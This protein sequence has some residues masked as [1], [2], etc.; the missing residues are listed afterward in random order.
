MINNVF[1]FLTQLAKR[2]IAFRGTLA[3]LAELMGFDEEEVINI[4]DDD[5]V[6]YLSSGVKGSVVRFGPQLSDA[7]IE[8]LKNNGTNVSSDKTT[9]YT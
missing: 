5:F 6:E 8:Y 2:Y 4:E 7:K 9:A 1:K 3:E